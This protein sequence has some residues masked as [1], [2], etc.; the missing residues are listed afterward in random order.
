VEED[1][2]ERALAPGGHDLDRRNVS[3]DEAKHSILRQWLFKLEACTHAGNVDDGAG[4]A[5]AC[6][7]KFRRPIGAKPAAGRRRR[8]CG[9]TQR[10]DV[11]GRTA[12]HVVL[13][14]PRLSVQD[15]AKATGLR[16]GG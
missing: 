10:S 2:Q 1:A 6:D 7:T 3:D 12:C 9:P 16:Q 15:N 13:L 8:S 5:N 4:N 11:W 14:T